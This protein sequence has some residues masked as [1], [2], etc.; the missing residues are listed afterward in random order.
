MSASTNAILQ[1]A[2]LTKHFPIRKG[3]LKR[4]VGHVHAVNGVSFTIHPGESLGLVGE[5][6]CGKTTLGKCVVFLQRPTGGRVVFKGTDL[7]RISEQELRRLRPQFQ[8]VFQDPFSTL[9][10]RMSVEAMLG[11]PLMLYENLKSG[12]RRPEGLQATGDGR[13]SAGAQQSLSP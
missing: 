8:M 3:V 4:T 7:G 5:S 6:G 13:P 9:N 10:P 11:E 1:V 12:K 2:D